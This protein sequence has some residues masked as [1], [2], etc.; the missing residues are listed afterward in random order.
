MYEPSSLNRYGL[1]RITAVFCR[2]V[3]HA[4]CHAFK[5]RNHIKLI[6]ERN[7]TR[8]Y[9]EYHINEQRLWNLFTLAK[10][11]VMFRC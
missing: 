11:N 4:C 7:N 2:E 6:S 5:Q 3:T 8:K 10:H 9:T 1:N